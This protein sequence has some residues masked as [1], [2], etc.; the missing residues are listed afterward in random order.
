MPTRSTYNILEMRDNLAMRNLAVLLEKFSSF[1]GESWRFLDKPALRVLKFLWN[2]S[3]Y[4]SVGHDA[5]ISGVKVVSVAIASIYPTSL[6][7]PLC[8]LSARD[9][10]RRAVRCKA[11]NTLIFLK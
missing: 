10:W 11:R 6:Y 3:N 8:I 9:A 1:W 7:T 2:F 5:S 4:S